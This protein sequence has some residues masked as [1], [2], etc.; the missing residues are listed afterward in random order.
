M[1]VYMRHLGPMVTEGRPAKSRRDYVELYFDPE[2]NDNVVDTIV[3]EGYYITRGN[4]FPVERETRTGT[5]FYGE[6]G[7]DMEHVGGSTCR[8]VPSVTSNRNNHGNQIKHSLMS[9]VTSAL[10]FLA[11]SS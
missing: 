11:E 8:Q 5:E 9:M 3:A 1:Q 4:E 6:T 10:D 2:G 7:A